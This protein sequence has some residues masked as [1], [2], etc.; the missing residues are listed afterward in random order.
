[1]GRISH[2]YGSSGVSCLEACTVKYITINLL[3]FTQPHANAQAR[4]HHL[5]RH[6]R[7]KTMKR[8][9][10][11]FPLGI[12]TEKYKHTIAMA[13]VYRKLCCSLN[14]AFF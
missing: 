2:L 7:A 13:W 11:L 1:M 8:N 14:L 10:L 4:P 12:S 9:K 5:S 3:E 6:F